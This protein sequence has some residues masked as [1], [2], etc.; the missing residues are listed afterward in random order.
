MA[1]VSSFFFSSQFHLIPR[2]S[3]SI[4]ELAFAAHQVRGL[5]TGKPAHG[6]AE[7]DRQRLST[8]REE[9]LRRRYQRVRHGAQRGFTVAQA[10]VPRRLW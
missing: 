1:W 3:S 9:I 4:D 8:P 6:P 2:A 7:D 10:N 5:S